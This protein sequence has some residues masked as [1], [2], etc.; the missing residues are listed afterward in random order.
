[1]PYWRYQGAWGWWR[2][3]LSRSPG[4]W[5]A[6]GPPPSSLRLALGRSSSLQRWAFKFVI[7]NIFRIRSLV[8]IF[9][10]FPRERCTLKTIKLWSKV[11]IFFGS[12]ISFGS[13]Y[14]IVVPVPQ[15]FEYLGSVD[16]NPMF[17]ILIEMRYRIFIK[18]YFF[19]GRRVSSRRPSWACSGSRGRW[20]RRSPVD[21]HPKRIQHPWLRRHFT[22]KRYR[23]IDFEIRVP[24]R[25][26]CLKHWFIDRYL[27]QID[28][29]GLIYDKLSKK[30]FEIDFIN[31]IFMTFDVGTFVNF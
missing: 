23:K 20:P 5:A 3:R 17:R 13:A 11:Q 28:N 4:A 31:R 8:L 30:N 21:P 29:T 6:P 16:F 25:F 12:G 1:M 19:S 24:Y 26:V 18:F 10:N 2:D 14:R 7:L 9:L 27:L 15:E 22:P